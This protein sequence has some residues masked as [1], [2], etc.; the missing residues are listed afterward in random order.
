MM[1]A[2]D[3]DIDALLPV[4]MGAGTERVVMGP[5]LADLLRAAEERLDARGPLSYRTEAT[6]DVL[7]V[8]VP[9]DVL[10]LLA[11]PL[12]VDDE[13]AKTGSIAGSFVGTGA[14]RTGTLDLP[15]GTANGQEED[16][17]ELLPRNV[18]AQPPSAGP[19]VSTAASDRPRT[20]TITAMERDVR[21]GQTVNAT[22]L[23]GEAARE[24]SSSSKVSEERDVSAESGPP[25]A[26]A[27]RR[28]AE[29]G[30]AIDRGAARIERA[31]MAR[32]AEPPQRRVT[33]E[34]PL[35]GE[36]LLQPE[37]TPSP[38]RGLPQDRPSQPERSGER[39]FPA[40]RPSQPERPNA[41][42]RGGDR[43]GF[44]ERN[45]VAE[46]NSAA[47]RFATAERN[48]AKDVVPQAPRTGP[49]FEKP[50][51][52]QAPH[53]DVGYWQTARMV[54]AALV[55]VSETAGPRSRGH[56]TD[57][58]PAV[59][60]PGD[61]A[62]ALGRAITNRASGAIAITQGDEQRRV[63]LHDGD[64]V[65]AGSSAPIESLVAFLSARGDIHR[66]MVPRLAG[67][68]PA[69]GRHAGAA[70]V[71]Q[72]NLGQDDLWPA[73]RAHAE[74][75]IARVLLV[76]SGTCELEV[77]PPARYKAEPSVFGG[78]TGAEVFVEAVQRAIAPEMAL[79]RLGGY[80]ARLAPGPRM[81]L[82][83]ECA[84]TGDEE[85]AVRAAAGR[86]VHELT[87][88]GPTERWSMLYALTCLDVIEALPPVVAPQKR[89]EVKVD[90]I[91]EEAIRMKVRAR[92]ALVE[93]GDYFALLGVPRT[94]TG[95]EI[96]HAY[97]ELRRT[98]EPSRM[99]TAGTADLADEVRLVAE[100][101]EEAYEILRDD[102][103]RERY[104]RA[105]EA[106]PPR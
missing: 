73:L 48:A 22:L 103:R 1:D 7:E 50:T 79:L 87:G 68:L 56:R 100:V 6:D 62:R 19:R 53:G 33:G 84:L 10:R 83:A 85:D 26:P 81:G 70:L 2:I 91:D 67:K 30:I 42:E 60:G 80:G 88:D 78:A 76:E 39:A 86:S 16:L 55:D 58:T 69:F 59:L 74:W 82:L 95:Y 24:V 89:P 47:E 3:L 21:S 31:A 40:D 13:E 94:A 25:V 102:L 101:V 104:R 97:L 66:D 44:A 65:T 77:E 61:A 92:V 5:D 57:T 11:E 72:G 32:N 98:F 43:F 105:I 17:E 51:S 14:D 52:L 15:Q 35:T 37:R 93:E 45:S 75:V 96:R 99:L 20:N 90:P 41:S 29:R 36:H 28:F 18:G 27:M 8:P 4:A 106:G 9:E 12:E 38:E 23:H 34:R 63:V 54:P 46:R 49:M 64:I 71:A